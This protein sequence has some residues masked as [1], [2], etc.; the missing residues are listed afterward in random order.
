MERD[1]VRVFWERY[2]DGEPTILL[3]PTWEIVHSRSWRCQIPYL[4]RHCR[5][6]CFDPR[7]NGRSD[8]P[9][10]AVGVRPASSRQTTRSRC[11]TRTASSSA[12]V[13]LAG[14][15]AREV[16]LA[17]PSI[18]DRVAA[19]GA[20]RAEHS[21]VSP[22][23]GDALLV[24][25]RARHR[26][27]AGRRRT[28]TTGRA[29]G[30]ATS[31]SSTARASAS[32]TRRSR[33]RTPSA[34]VSRPMR[35]RSSLGIGRRLAST[36][37][38]APTLPAR[39]GCPVLLVQ[40]TDDR[41]RRRRALAP[42]SPRGCRTRGWCVIE[43]SRPRA[44]PARPGRAF[45]RLLRDFAAPP[46]PP[47]R[48]VRGPAGDAACPLRL[49][50]DRPRPRAS[51]SRDRRP[52]CA[53]LRPGLEVDWLAQHPVT[54]VLE[55]GGER[56]HPASA[57]LAS[58]S[59]AH[60]AR[61]ARPRAA[62]LPG[63]AADGRDPAGELHGVPRRR[64]ATSSYDLWIGDEAWERRPLPAREPRAE[65]RAVR[66]ADRLR[67]LPADARG[68]RARGV[69]DGRLQRGDDRARRPLPAH[70]RPGDLRRR[71]R[72]HRAGQ[73]R[74]GPAGGSATG[75]MRPL[76]VRGLRDRLRRRSTATDRVELRRQL[77]YADDETVCVVAVGGSGVG[78]DLLRRRRSRRTRPRPRASPGLR[79]VVVA[80]PRIDPGIAAAV[81]AG[82]EVHGYVDRLD[83]HLAGGRRRGRA[84]RPHDLHGAD[85][86]PAAVPLLPA[87]AATSSSSCTSQHRL[88]RYRRGA[89]MDYETAD[90]TGHRRRDRPGAD[91]AGRLPAGRDGR[92]RP[93]AA[94]LLADLF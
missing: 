53:R 18:P 33:S 22:I 6:I 92:E 28:V 64:R 40:G 89:A 7:G 21:N 82:V 14:A 91:A 48:W 79:M 32:R 67:R 30:R 42:R 51:R 73:V 52:S 15:A 78:G 69:P 72:R 86:E 10:E 37:T 41:H 50:A 45:N 70:P 16:L 76:R 62:L 4:A 80:G 25:R 90:E 38:I 2:G 9:R 46:P 27:R 87:R 3:M 68:R 24:R 35:T 77:G 26:R 8:R 29:T 94:A 11:S 5:V 55:A 61:V 1:G 85:G 93:R 56:V 17:T 34:G 49:V 81:R 84:G 59:H 13:V 44:A 31:S 71:P 12:I 58:E 20:D 65:A 63:A 19:A 60:G 83:R 54:E 43:G 39:A 88:R 57:E 36:P 75:P 47:S 74:S 23:P 66:L